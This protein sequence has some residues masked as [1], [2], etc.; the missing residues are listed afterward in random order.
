MD[1]I[2]F[3]NNSAPDLSAETLNQI[4]NNMEEVGVAVS[5]TEPTTGEKVWIDKSNNSIYVK[6]DNGVYEKFISVN[7]IDERINTLYNPVRKYT[8][9]TVDGVSFAI[10]QLKTGPLVTITITA[11]NVPANTNKS[12]FEVDYKPISEIHA[13][14]QFLGAV[15]GTSWITNWDNGTLWINSGSGGTLQIDFVY[16]TN[17]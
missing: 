15:K 9:K 11:Q 17:E 10:D 12:F 7:D 2:N 13:I 3:V 4:Q 8:E 14:C 16:V 1:K 6:N 5:P